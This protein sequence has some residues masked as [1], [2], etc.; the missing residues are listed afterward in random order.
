[1]IS[2]R[3]KI[4]RSNGFEGLSTFL[5]PVGHG[6]LSQFLLKACCANKGYSCNSDLIDPTF[7]A[8]AFHKNSSDPRLIETIKG[9]RLRGV[10]KQL[11]PTPQCRWNGTHQ[12][13]NSQLWSFTTTK[14]RLQKWQV[15]SFA[16][17]F[18][19]EDSFLIPKNFPMPGCFNLLCPVSTQQSG[20]SC[21]VELPGKG[22]NTS[23][24]V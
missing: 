19:I 17:F 9:Q 16:W 1:M 6:V 11:L 3:K 5:T 24:R 18:P 2:S 7:A 13:T 22:K 8:A 23:K 14:N 4:A 20:T 15:D 21:D 12:L 10:A